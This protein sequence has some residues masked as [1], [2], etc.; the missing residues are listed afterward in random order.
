VSDTWQHLMRE[1]FAQGLALDDV[2][3]RLRSAGASQYHSVRALSEVKNMKMYDADQLVLNSRTWSDTRS[4]MVEF[5]K[6]MSQFY[7]DTSPE[8]T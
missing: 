7:G 3:E 8:D 2:L 6:D 4:N 1:L 5:R